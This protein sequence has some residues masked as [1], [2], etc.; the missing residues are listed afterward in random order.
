MAVYSGASYRISPIH[1]LKNFD[2]FS[3]HYGCVVKLVLH[4]TRFVHEVLYNVSLA[5]KNGTSRH[6]RCKMARG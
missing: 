6:L 4:E 3:F 5:G 1:H 2:V